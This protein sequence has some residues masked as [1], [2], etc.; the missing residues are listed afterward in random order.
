MKQIGIIGLVAILLI[1]GSPLLS[2]KDNYKN[3]KYE[4][5]GT[6]MLGNV[7]SYVSVLD[8]TGKAANNTINFISDSLEFISTSIKTVRDFVKGIFEHSTGQTCNPNESGNG[9]FTCGSSDGGGGGSFGGG[10]R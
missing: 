3:M 1:F 5:I 6:V 8:T 7:E 4:E 9:G 10:S 2:V